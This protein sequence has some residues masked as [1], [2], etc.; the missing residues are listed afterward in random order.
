MCSKSYLNNKKNSIFPQQLYLT[1]N[2]QYPDLIESLGSVYE[3]MNARTKLFPQLSKLQGKLQLVMSQVGL[4]FLA[5]WLKSPCN[6]ELIVLLNKKKRFHPKR[7][8]FSRMRRRTRSPCSTTR[9]RR[10]RTSRSRMS[11]SPVTRSTTSIASRTRTTMRRTRTRRM[12][13][14]MRTRTS[15]WSRTMVLLLRKRCSLSRRRMP[16]SPRALCSNR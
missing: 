1:L 9:T 5:N 2:F 16:S 14:M 8:V 3:M 7:R 13:T 11:S 4:F 6:I 12:T 10:A 15:S